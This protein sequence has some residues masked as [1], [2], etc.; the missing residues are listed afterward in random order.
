MRQKT[1]DGIG[2][3]Q[4][5][6]GGLCYWMERRAPDPYLTA[7]VL[8]AAFLAKH[9]G[10]S[11]DA[12][13][14]G[15]AVKW[16]EKWA[17]TQDQNWAYPYSRSE[18]YA[19]KAYAVYVLT[20]YGRPLPG[21][22]GNLYEVRAQIPLE[23][24]AWLLKAAPYMTTGKDVTGKLAGELMSAA[25][26][27]PQT[28]HFEDT[29]VDGSSWLHESTAKTTAVCLE[30]LLTA[31]KGFP[32][33]EKAVRWLVDEQKTTG[34][35]RTTHENALVLRALSAF[36]K[37]YEK[38]GGTFSAYLYSRADG[39]QKALWT[40][41]F[42]NRAPLSASYSEKLRDLMPAVADSVKL[43]FSKTG[44]GRLYYSLALKYS[45]K[46]YAAKEWEGFELE[47]KITPLKAS[48]SA[49]LRAPD[50][51]IVTLTVRTKQDRSFVALTD[52]LP[53][54]FEVVDPSFAVEGQNDAA[55][56]AKDETGNWW[57]GFSRHENYDDTVMAFADYLPAGEYTY[58][59]LV[60]ATTPGNYA[61]PAAYVE[62]MYEPEVFAH[63]AS[64]SIEIIH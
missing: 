4:H 5:P 48:G 33:D 49:K 29:A 7:Y 6:S 28:I 45:P 8:D 57:E 59:Y 53:A 44:P 26:I 46:S 21:V 20:L 35:W 34:R 42:V 16:L 52:R 43:L 11:V 23:G 10:Y 55:A 3:Y 58:S 12:A 1:L 62:Q 27:A 14:T 25:Q 39:G 50:R 54:G 19:A 40:G 41:E 30:A 47:K 32:G 37:L 56:L 9:S 15:K 63:T 36:Y 64:G 38:D 31:K 17:L 18:E 2:D 51:A 22:F 60:Q 24:R 61:L 13:V